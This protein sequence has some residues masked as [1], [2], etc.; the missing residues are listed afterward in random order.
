[1]T[2]VLAGFEPLAPVSQT[3]GRTNTVRLDRRAPDFLNR[4]FVEIAVP[5]EEA[6]P[7]KGTKLHGTQYFATLIKNLMM[8]LQK[9]V[10]HVG[11]GVIIINIGKATKEKQAFVQKSVSSLL[12]FPEFPI[13]GSNIILFIDR[14]GHTHSQIFWVNPSIGLF[15]C[16]TEFDYKEFAESL[17][18]LL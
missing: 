17:K 6:N 12:T 9:M 8:E 11:E 16:S 2:F 13:P 10:P 14:R 3:E 1:V 4:R 5:K 15:L 7:F 18:R